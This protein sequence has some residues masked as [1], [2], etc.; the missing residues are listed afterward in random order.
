VHIVCAEHVFS[1]RIE[2]ATMNVTAVDEPAAISVS[3]DGANVNVVSQ[4]GD[5]NALVTF[6][7]NSET[8]L[9]S[10]VGCIS[11][12]AFAAECQTPGAEGL[13]TPFG[14]TVNPDGHFG[15]ALAWIAAETAAI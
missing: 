9:L 15:A 14:V 6:S 2:N 8:G 7:R 12:E 13:N 10:K 1:V 4:G 3:P 11:H 5:P